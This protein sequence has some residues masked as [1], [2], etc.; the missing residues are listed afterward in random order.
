MAYIII[1]A[2]ILV[3]G[4]ILFTVFAN[5][6]SNVEIQAR[7][8]FFQTVGLSEMI[9]N[10]HETSPFGIPN[11]GNAMM[12]AYTDGTT[13]VTFM[14]DDMVRAA[15]NRGKEPSFTEPLVAVVNGPKGQRMYRVENLGIPSLMTIEIM[16]KD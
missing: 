15:A 13:T 11:S 6:V 5:H 3:V 4:R 8:R 14:W 7:N 16:D 12:K 1:I 9:S 10:C 2:F